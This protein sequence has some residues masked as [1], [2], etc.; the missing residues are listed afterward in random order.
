[1]VLVSSRS[2]A[3]LASFSRHYASVWK[4][5]GLRGVRVAVV[6]D[7]WTAAVRRSSPFPLTTGSALAP[8][9]ATRRSAQRVVH[10][11]AEALSAASGR[12]AAAQLPGGVFFACVMRAESDDALAAG[13]PLPH[14]EGDVVRGPLKEAHA[15]P[16]GPEPRTGV[17][18]RRPCSPSGEQRLP[19]VLNRSGRG[20]KRRRFAQTC[21]AFSP[22]AG[23][24]GRS[25][26]GPFPGQEV[27]PQHPPR[28]HRHGRA[29]TGESVSRLRGP[30][31]CVIRAAGHVLPTLEPTSAFVWCPCPSQDTAVVFTRM[32]DSVVELTSRLESRGPHSNSYSGAEL[33]PARASQSRGASAD[34]VSRALKLAALSRRRR[35][36]VEAGEAKRVWQSGGPLPLTSASVQLITRFRRVRRLRVSSF[37][38]AL[39]TPP[40]KSSKKCTL[41]VSYQKRP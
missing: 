35:P 36:A 30:R 31:Q 10:I 15:P 5:G 28:H 40:P 39:F 19:N 13:V 26:A 11:D 14:G 29:L 41:A 32:L 27:R 9:H 4:A 7:V 12:P 34:I 37:E 8:G 3:E 6:G 21:A 2:P 20:P 24:R 25:G 18:G 38:F 33:V 22:R 1:M 23:A 16:H 17:A